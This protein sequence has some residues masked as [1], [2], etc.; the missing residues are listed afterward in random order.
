MAVR[1]PTHEELVKTLYPDKTLYGSIMLFVTGLVGVL[2]VMLVVSVDVDYADIVPAWIRHWPPALTLGGSL[3]AGLFGYLSIEKRALPWPYLGVLAGL[4]SFGG[5]G[6]TSLLSLVALLFIVLGHREG[7]FHNPATRTLPASAWPDKSMAASLLSLVSGVTTLFWGL[8][9]TIGIIE[10][11]DHARDAI[12][13]GSFAMVVG[14]LN[15][16]AALA[17][18]A[19][20]LPR[21]GLAA[22][23]LC[24]LGAGFVAIGPLLAV[25]N[26]WFIALALREGEFRPRRSHVVEV[27]APTP[28]ARARRARRAR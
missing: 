18:Y 12:V 22:A 24:G 6:V 3:L 15:I 13:L 19:Q 10:W 4:A 7:E 23:A 1:G 11:A 28:P 17:L 25:A 27:P 21:L 8:L 16:I 5:V 26:V 20:Q 14:G 2:W 9:F